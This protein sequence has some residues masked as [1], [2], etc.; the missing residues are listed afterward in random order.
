[1][2]ETD[3]YKRL[4]CEIQL[5]GYNPLEERQQLAAA[6][7]LAPVVYKLVREAVK[8]ATRERA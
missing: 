2:N 7:R 6:R 5:R 4:E 8:E 3:I 1:V